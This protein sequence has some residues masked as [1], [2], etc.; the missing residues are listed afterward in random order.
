MSEDI[1]KA[2][3]ATPPPDPRIAGSRARHLLELGIMQENV[4]KVGSGIPTP[5]ELNQLLP[6]FD[7]HGLIGKGG[8][9]A[10]YRARQKSL[11][12]LV[13][14]KVLTRP[15]DSEAGF[16]ERF[17]REA[18]ALASLSHPGIVAVHDFGRAG[19]YWY[20]AMEYVDGPDLRRVIDGKA[21][22]PREAL[23][24]VSQVCEALQYAHD[25]GVVH[26]DIKPGN[27]LLDREGHV[28]ITD[29]GLAKLVGIRPSPALTR[30]S[31]VMGTPHYMAPEQVEAPLEVDH[32]ADLYSVGVVLYELLTGELP[33]GNF[34]P[35][36]HRVQVDVRLDEVVARALMKDPGERY[37]SAAEVRSDVD[38]VVAHP[39]RGRMRKEKRSSNW[40]HGHVALALFAGLAFV[41]LLV[42]R[43]DFLAGGRATGGGDARYV[44]S[45]PV[46]EPYFP[47]DAV[48]MRDLLVEEDGRI[49]SKTVEYDES[50]VPHVSEH[51]AK[52]FGMGADAVAEADRYLGVQREAY[53]ALE[54]VH[55]TVQWNRQ[56]DAL[57]F[58]C[59]DF[60]RD[61]GDL[62]KHTMT[63]LDGTLGGR[64]IPVAAAQEIERTLFPLGQGMST[65][66]L[67]LKES[68]PSL[69]V[70]TETFGTFDLQG[71]RIDRE[72]GHLLEDLTQPPLSPVPAARLL[73]SA[74][75]Q[76]EWDGLR[77]TV[78]ELDGAER[79]GYLNNNAGI[80]DAP[81]LESLINCTLIIELRSDQTPNELPTDIQ[82]ADLQVELQAHLANQPGFSDLEIYLRKLPYPQS[83]DSDYLRARIHLVAQVPG[84]HGTLGAGTLDLTGS[85]TGPRLAN[86]LLEAGFG[87]A[88]ETQV[89][90]SVVPLCFAQQKVYLTYM[91]NEGLESTLKIFEVLEAFERTGKVATVNSFD[92]SH[93]SAGSTNHLRMTTDVVT[94]KAWER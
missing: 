34:P 55:A 60:A 81:I 36:S 59:R 77:W 1:N 64:T 44:P 80:A 11:D 35:P 90:E 39:E 4:H 66:K 75:A 30:S 57:L 5:E 48:E 69:R 67:D 8:M 65:L 15:P 87:G 10:V 23:S 7:V 33:L 14:L 25:Q 88:T 31:Q 17:Q 78:S 92:I 53:V 84:S 37:Q 21:M 16:A 61:R 85:S 45:Y 40:M 12:R 56:S 68:I 49:V 38:D 22:T 54:R 46:N 71:E 70:N 50:G 62:V 19:E 63:L 89:S 3:R 42:L 52:V 91:G 43:P 58:S 74:L 86:A 29:F 2:R 41:A 26:R 76:F 79:R 13:A 32:R 51:F 72:F 27:V 93:R 28:K 20:I 83:P 9:G 6:E 82:Q 47:P 24:I 94:R 73:L 18:L